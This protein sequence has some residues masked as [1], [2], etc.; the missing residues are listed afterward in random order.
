MQANLRLKDLQVREKTTSKLMNV[1]IPL[2]VSDAIH[3]VAKRSRV[4]KTDVVI[5]LLNEALDI[6]NLQIE[7]WK[8]PKSTASP[9]KKAC[10]IEGCGKAPRRKGSASTTTRR[11]DAASYRKRRRHDPPR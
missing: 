8:P 3:S 1:K 10:S 7:G 11:P 6:T 9:P 5:A 2:A 4:S